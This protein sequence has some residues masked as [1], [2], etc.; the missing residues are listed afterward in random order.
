MPGVNF[1]VR[2]VGYFADQPLFD[3]L[4]LGGDGT[5][6]RVPRLTGLSEPEVLAVVA[7]RCSTE[8]ALRL[9]A[10]ARDAYRPLKT[11]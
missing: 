1:T 3:V 11:A 8:A 6:T 10:G 2:Q 5:W 9:L 4:E 7:R